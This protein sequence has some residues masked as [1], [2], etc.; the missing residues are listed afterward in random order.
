MG[1][2]LKTISP[3]TKTICFVYGDSLKFGKRYFAAIG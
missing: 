2:Y 3:F 1:D